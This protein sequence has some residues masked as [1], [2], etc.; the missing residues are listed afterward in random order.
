MEMR[1][2]I[3]IKDAVYSA[4]GKKAPRPFTQAIA[5]AVHPQPLRVG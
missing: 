5:L 1:R 2:L 4:A 3:V